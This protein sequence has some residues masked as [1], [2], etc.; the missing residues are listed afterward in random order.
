MNLD[1][2]LSSGARGGCSWDTGRGANPP[3]P[4]RDRSPGFDR[5]HPGKQA[6]RELLVVANGYQH[7]RGA[8][9]H[10]ELTPYARVD[11]MLAAR[12]ADC[13]EDLPHAPDDPAVARAYA[14]FRDEILAQWR[15]LEDSGWV[16][17][18]WLEEGQPYET[19]AEMVADARAGHLFIFLGGDFPEGHLLMAP[20]GVVRGGLPLS[21]NDLFRA[22]HDIFG[23]ALYGN[24]FG[25]R[26]EEHA[27]R[28][29]AA[30]FST[31][32]L[33]AMSAETRGQ[34]AWFNFGRH[35]R[36]RD[37]PVWER[38]YAQQKNILLPLEFLGVG[39]APPS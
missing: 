33:P 13:Y 24:G 6:C 12:V 22:V 3:W 1:R 37:V 5:S 21:S 4:S 35:V 32:A 8:A 18:P 17:E 15:H 19:S 36:G 38:P 34:N 14:A 39:A 30:M 20:S 16:V 9:P 23:H 29:H 28:T 25:P 2:R 11:E 31:E 7:S 27:W 26:G 10:P